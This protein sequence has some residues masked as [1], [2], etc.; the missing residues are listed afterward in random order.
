MPKARIFITIMAD[1]ETEEEVES[2][3]EKLRSDPDHVKDLVLAQSEKQ[4]VNIVVMDAEESE[5][6]VADM[7][8]MAEFL[9]GLWTD[10]MDPDGAEEFREKVLDALVNAGQERAR[11]EFEQGTD[12]IAATLVTQHGCYEAAKAVLGYF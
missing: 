5:Q 8:R 9:E 10:A 11:M 12:A 7:K 4:I 3:S 2:L 6:R 1:V